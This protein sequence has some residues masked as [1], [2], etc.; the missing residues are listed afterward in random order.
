MIDHLALAVPEVAAGVL[1]VE[2]GP[3]ARLVATVETP[4]GIKVLS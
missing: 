3:S 2:A 4:R 1:V